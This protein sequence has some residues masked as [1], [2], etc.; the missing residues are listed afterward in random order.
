MQQNNKLLERFIQ[1]TFKNYEAFLQ[2]PFYQR[3]RGALAIFLLNAATAFAWHLLLKTSSE[4]S[5]IAFWSVLYFYAIIIVV[6]GY[7]GLALLYPQ[8]RQRRYFALFFTVL[9][10]VGLTYGVAL[11]WNA[12]IIESQDGRTPW[13]TLGIDWKGFILFAAIFLSVYGGLYLYGLV[14]NAIN[15]EQLRTVGELDAAR[16][17]QQRFV[18]RVQMATN[19]FWAFGNT[20]PSNEVGGDYFDIVTVDNRRTVVAIGDVS[21]HNIA[22]GLLMAVTKS[23]FRTELK[24]LQPGQESL[25][26]VMFGLNE[27]I[28]E[29]VEK[30][31]FVSFQCALYNFSE[32]TLCIANAGHLPILHLRPAL[33]RI[34]EIL[35]RGMALG[36]SKNAVIG[37]HSATFQSGDLF[38]FYTDGILEACNAANVEFGLENLK[39]VLKK[40][41]GGQEPEKLYDTILAH[42]RTYIGEQQSA[43][44]F[45]D[46]ATL[47]ILRIQ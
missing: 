37:F 27:I 21:G 24:H 47:T 3:L 33:G 8:L 41:G 22:A 23:A 19:T 15:K 44:N 38:L 4:S 30:G 40:H 6:I 1:S 43:L 13:Q 31:L 28:C 32:K 20:I 10:I 17:I 2:L 34:E 7:I 46:D 39:T 45:A 14:M 16:I 11:G 25:E 29:N 36:M 5:P 9:V 12:A 18:P 26:K 42:I 35:P